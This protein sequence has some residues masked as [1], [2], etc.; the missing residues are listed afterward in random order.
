MTTRLLSPQS[1]SLHSER[2]SANA[3]GT[4]R[5]PTRGR[6]GIE[7]LTPGPPALSLGPPAVLAYFKSR[8]G[9][10][11]G[12]LPVL[13]KL[14]IERPQ[15][16]IVGILAGER[17]IR[18]IDQQP[19]LYSEL[20]KTLDVLV[21]QTAPVRKARGLLGQGWFGQIAEKP[22][23]FAHNAVS[24][25]HRQCVRWST[26]EVLR[27]LRRENVRFILKDHGSDDSFLDLLQKTFPA[28]CVGAPH[29]TGIYLA[30]PNSNPCSLQT[31]KLDLFLAGHSMEIPCLESFLGESN[32]ARIRVV[33]RPRYDQWWIDHLSQVPE[34]LVSEECRRAARFKRTF[35]F[36]TRGPSQRFLPEPVYQYLV[37]S[38]AEVVLRDPG[39]LLLIKPHPQQNIRA[40]SALLADWPSNQ[41]LI[42]SFQTMQLARL[43]DMAICMVSGVILDAL[44][45]G[46]PTVEFFRYA[47]H[48]SESFF[49][50]AS[51]RTVSAYG[52]LGLVVRAE[53]KEE[54]AACI[55]E[56][57]AGRSTRWQEQRRKAAAFLHLDN[58][59][60]D[61]VLEA[62]SSLASTVNPG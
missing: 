33:G 12:Y 23:A 56:F 48:A 5:I 53:T 43:A 13:S 18:T 3:P 19:F 8:W 44:A 25:F 34:F 50:D 58:R 27:Y 28:K 54:L 15:W 20:R 49:A 60:T 55:D 47:P 41:W 7:L 2:R 61:R 31:I 38:A 45:V 62:M 57:F 6:F 32:R 26:R 1:T 21:S 59:S 39:H 9:E 52:H 14:K 4:T 11:D 42:S 51:G 17:L 16:R 22:M 36:A 29:G 30:P 46:K 24:W 10:V 40:L 35:L 37:R